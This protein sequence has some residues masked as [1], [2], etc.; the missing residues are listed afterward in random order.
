MY[1]EFRSALIM[2]L[3]DLDPE[4]L[5]R[6][7]AA[8]DAVAGDFTITKAELGLS[9]IGREELEKIIK[10][11]IVCKGIEGCSKNTLAGYTLALMNFKDRI[12]KPIGEITVND[13]RQYLITYKM[14]NGIS[15][16]SL[17]HLRTILNSFF[18]WCQNEGHVTKSPMGAIKPIKYRKIRKPA[19]DPEELERLRSCCRDDRERALVEVL[20]STGCR[21]SE[22]INARIDDIN[23]NVHPVTI[24]II[25]KGNKP[26]IVY[27]SPRAVAALRKYLAGRRY[28]STY[29]FN[30]NRA[31][32]QMSKENA[33]KIFRQLRKLAGLE[34]KRLTPH[35]L[36]HTLGTNLALTVPI[37]VVQRTLRHETIDTTMIYAET[38]DQDVVHYHARVMI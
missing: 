9:V 6:I 14:E 26:G 1:S 37:Q 32:G 19:L 28:A 3:S 29:I 35:T 5:Q 25:G 15:D 10:L 7:L 36:R 22:I 17:D 12:M 16:R 34:E 18:T 31:G 20:Y 30:N 23:F 11:Y 27:M 24:K 21:I 2:K 8:L 4:Q 38:S 13:M 33:E